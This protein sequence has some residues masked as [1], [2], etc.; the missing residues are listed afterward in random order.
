MLITCIGIMS[1]I[2]NYWTDRQRQVFREK[3][4]DLL[5]WGKKPKIIHA[6]YIT[7][8]G[9]L[10]KSLLLVSGWWGIARH[11][12]YV[13]ELSVAYAWCLPTLTSGLLGY[14][15][16]IF[17][18]ILLIDRAYRDELRCAEKY[19][20]FYEEYCKIVK[21]KMIPKVY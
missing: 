11:I 4:G 9:K 13:F 5:I 19:G 3:N 12:N 21:W 6:N 15:Y 14:F 10:R 16:S 8:D 7:G 18:T 20:E 1:L 17:L 2:C